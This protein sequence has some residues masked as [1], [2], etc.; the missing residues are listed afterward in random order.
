MTLKTEAEARKLWCPFA[1]VATLPPS[2]DDGLQCAVNR[3]R[4][5]NSEL[6]KHCLCIASACMAW[7]WS[8]L[9]ANKGKGYCTA[10]PGA[11]P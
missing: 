8:L 4:R 6:P 3:S 7:E 2:R 5:P 1:R 10:M 11:K 9:T